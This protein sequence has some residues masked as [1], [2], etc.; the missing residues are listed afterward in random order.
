[1]ENIDTQARDHPWNS[2]PCA[3]YWDPLER[4]HPSAVWGYRPTADSKTGNGR[5]PEL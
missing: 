4:F 1:M 3:D 2:R 5:R